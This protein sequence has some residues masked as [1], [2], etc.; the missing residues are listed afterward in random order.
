MLAAIA[1]ILG[2]VVLMARGVMESDELWLWVGVPLAGLGV[3]G[4]VLAVRMHRRRL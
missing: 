2:G 3:V 4:V 1:C